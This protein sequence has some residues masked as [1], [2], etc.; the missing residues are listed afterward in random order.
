[1]H[2]TFKLCIEWGEK[3]NIQDVLKSKYIGE[4]FQDSKRRVWEV[5]SQG[6]CRDKQSLIL[7][8]DLNNDEDFIG[9]NIERLFFLSDIVNLYF[10][11]IDA[12]YK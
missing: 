3:M 7:V 10:K 12:Q 5:K 8:K 6:G 1:M 4:K 9:F 2:N 11:K